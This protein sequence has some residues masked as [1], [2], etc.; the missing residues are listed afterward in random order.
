MPGYVEQSL[1]RFKHQRPQ[2]SQHQLYPHVPPKYGAKQQLTEHEDESPILNKDSKKFVQE[3]CGTLLYYARVVDCTTLASLGSIATQQSAPTENTMKKINQLLDYVATHP[4]A[5]VT[6]RA[7]HTVLV[8][9]SNT[10]Y[11]SKTQSTKLSRGAFLPVQGQNLSQKQR[12][13]PHYLPNHQSR[14]VV[15]RGSRI[16]SALHQFPRSHPRTATT[17]GVGPQTSTNADAN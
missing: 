10:S 6:F 15:R 17:R 8:A 14:H 1:V 2:K 7:S 13:Y 9:H 4:A 3:V 11:L 5:A 16:G 12:I